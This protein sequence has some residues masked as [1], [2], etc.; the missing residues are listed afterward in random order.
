VR[1]IIYAAVNRSPEANRQVNSALYE[2]R[3]LVRPVTRATAF[4]RRSPTSAVEHTATMRWA[5]AGVEIATPV[6]LL[7]QGQG[8][9]FRSPA[10]LL[11][12]LTRNELA[13]LHEDGTDR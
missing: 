4:D 12:A 2:S 6:R 3:V 7:K 9:H 10:R 13:F 11:F 1:E 5:V 8:T